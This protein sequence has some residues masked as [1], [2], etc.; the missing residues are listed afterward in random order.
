MRQIGSAPLHA[1]IIKRAR[2]CVRL[3]LELG[4]ADPDAR[5]SHG[6]VPLMYAAYLDD[7]ETARML[8]AHGAKL[9]LRTPVC[10]RARHLSYGDF[11]CHVLS[12]KHVRQ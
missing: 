4:K 7:F 12:L 10:A 11:R 6:R 8:L 1:A 9:H 5:D 2:E 3:L